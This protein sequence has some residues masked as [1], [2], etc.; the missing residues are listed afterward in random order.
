MISYLLL[1][2]NRYLESIKGI[3]NIIPN[4]EVFDLFTLIYYP[5][6]TILQYCRLKIEKQTKFIITQS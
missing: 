6:Y 2:K 4:K 3:K 5:F 1:K